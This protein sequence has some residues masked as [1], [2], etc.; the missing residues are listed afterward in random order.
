MVTIGSGSAARASGCKHQE[1]A[2][3]QRGPQIFATRIIQR[4]KLILHLPH[5]LAVWNQLF[6]YRNTATTLVSSCWSQLR[7]G[8]TL[9]RCP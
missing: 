8:V 6:P 9:E 3:E 2:L 5:H 7:G 1:I 4:F